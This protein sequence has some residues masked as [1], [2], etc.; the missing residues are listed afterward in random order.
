MNRIILVTFTITLCLSVDY[1]HITGDAKT[2]KGYTG[3]AV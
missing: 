2:L 3:Q 1:Y